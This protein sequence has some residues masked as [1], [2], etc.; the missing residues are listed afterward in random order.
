MPSRWIGSNDANKGS[1][2]TKIISE[3]GRGHFLFAAAFFRE[4]T[5]KVD[6]VMISGQYQ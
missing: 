4:N 2:L 1:I 6:T 5:T 3:E